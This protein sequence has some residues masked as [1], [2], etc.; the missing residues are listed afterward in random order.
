MNNRQMCPRCR[1]CEMIVESETC[2]NCWGRGKFDLSADDPDVAP[3]EY[4]TCVECEGRGTITYER[5]L[6][7]CDKSGKHWRQYTRGFP[8]TV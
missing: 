1:C 4:E 6:G 8:R 3:G 7:R 2:W 5:C